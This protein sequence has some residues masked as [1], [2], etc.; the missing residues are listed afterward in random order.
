MPQFKFK[1]YYLEGVKILL[2][3]YHNSYNSSHVW[4]GVSRASQ[5]KN[6]FSFLHTPYT[7][8]HHSC[9]WLGCTFPSTHNT[10]SARVFLIFILYF[11]VFDG[12]F[13]YSHNCIPMFL[14][15]RSVKWF[16]QEIPDQFLCW[17]IYHH[18][19]SRFDSVYYIEISYVNVSSSFRTRSLS[20][21]FQ[22]D[23]TRVVLL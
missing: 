12:F 15:W 4:W 7:L 23:T 10:F 6:W 11:I 3:L 8:F 13:I 20:V 17:M 1:K 2:W 9:D 16:G 22:L 5:L 19:I 14:E 21:S 18:N